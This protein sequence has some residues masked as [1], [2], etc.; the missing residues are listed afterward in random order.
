MNNAKCRKTPEFET[1]HCMIHY[2]YRYFALF[3]SPR[4]L[5]IR[6]RS[7]IP[8]TVSAEY[9]VGWD[10]ISSVPHT[11]VRALHVKR[12]NS[13]LEKCYRLHR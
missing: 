1:T 4:S 9:R 6:N 13:M 5:K 12:Q 3:H 2:T 8:A 11:P 7:N 10:G